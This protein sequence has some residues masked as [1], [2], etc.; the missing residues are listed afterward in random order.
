MEDGADLVTGHG[1]LRI[2]DDGVPPPPTREFSGRVGVRLAADRPWRW[3]VQG[4]PN[5]SKKFVRGRSD[6]FDTSGRHRYDDEPSVGQ[7]IAGTGTYA[8]G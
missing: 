3:W 8:F 2:M 6:P 4:D 5:V 7:L 1:G